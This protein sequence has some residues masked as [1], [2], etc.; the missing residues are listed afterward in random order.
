MNRI[1][2]LEIIQN[3]ELY[4]N[5]LINNGILSIKECQSCHKNMFL[6]FETFIFRC[7]KRNNGA[8]CSTK[9]SLFGPN[10]IFYKAKIN[11][12]TIIML[13]YEFSAETN[14]KNTAFEYNL[15]SSTVSRYFDKLRE[16]S[17]QYYRT[18]QPRQIGG[19]GVIVEWDE[20]LLKE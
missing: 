5:F 20:C 4:V 10:H 9:L 3:E 19:E 12:K 1:M 2:L 6:N 15:D 17:I 18:N 11:F 13:L 8:K 14:I 16:I 7:N